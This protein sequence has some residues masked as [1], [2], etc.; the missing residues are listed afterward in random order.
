MEERGDINRETVDIKMRYANEHGV[1]FTRICSENLLN[2]P[3]ED[4]VMEE[5]NLKDLGLEFADII[6]LN[7]R[8]L[9][10]KNQR[11]I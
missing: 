3:E 8:T 10:W 2:T 6:R 5:V 1:G 11:R 4:E 7:R 9:N